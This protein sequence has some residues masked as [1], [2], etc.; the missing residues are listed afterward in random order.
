MSGIQCLRRTH[1][2]AAKTSPNRLDMSPLIERVR[3]TRVHAL[4]LPAVV[5]PFLRPPKFP[6]SPDYAFVTSLKKPVRAIESACD[7]GEKEDGERIRSLEHGYRYV[8]SAAAFGLR[9]S[10]RRKSQFMTLSMRIRLSTSHNAPVDVTS[11]IDLRKASA[12][13]VGFAN[14][15]SQ[16]LRRCRRV[17]PTRLHE[18]TRLKTC[19]VTCEPV[20]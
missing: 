14:V 13:Q 9:I 5:V 16:R 4:L 20:Q 11:V 2:R 6:L 10:L 1:A 3:Q 17:L 7:N 19:W 12:I 15:R 18:A 8:V